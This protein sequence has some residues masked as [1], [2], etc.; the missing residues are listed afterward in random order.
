EAKL[1]SL[2]VGTFDDFTITADKITGT[3]PYSLTK[4]AGAEN[5]V[6]NA[7][8][9][10]F[11]LSKYAR[12]YASTDGNNNEDGPIYS[13]GDVNGDGVS[14][15]QVANNRGLIFV[16]GDDHKVKVY[17]AGKIQSQEIN[18]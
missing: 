12:A 4:A 11:D 13:N 2:S 7:T 3:I 9:V 1:E 17:R 15:P 6:K 8:F 5:D 16:R 14:E 18:T 10:T